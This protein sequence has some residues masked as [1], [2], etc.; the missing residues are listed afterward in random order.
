MNNGASRTI[1]H[2]FAARAPSVLLASKSKVVRTSGNSFITQQR[3]SF[4]QWVAPTVTYSELK[5]LTR[6]PSVDRYVIDVREPDEVAAGAIPSSVSLPLSALPGA[7]HL[8]PDKF[9]N[10]Y[11]FEKPTKNQEL[12][13]YCRSGKRSTT[14]SEYA[15]EY[16]YSNIKN[17]VGSWQDWSERE[18]KKAE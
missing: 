17:Y 4:S 2:T 7:F 3:S 18:G 1:S 16:G 14:A 10:T 8:P 11:G 15:K 13:F 5:P 9:R 12:I 6:Q